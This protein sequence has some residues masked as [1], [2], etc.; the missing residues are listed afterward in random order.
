MLAIVANAARNIRMQM[1][2]LY[3]VF[4]PQGIFWPLAYFFF[5]EVSIYLIF[6]IFMGLNVFL[7]KFYQYPLYIFDIRPIIS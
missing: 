3:F 4:G 6:P 1:T 5:K 7:V 2:F